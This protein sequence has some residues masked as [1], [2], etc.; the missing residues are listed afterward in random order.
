MDPRLNVSVVTPQGV[1]FEGPAQHV[2][3]P[4]ER[5]IFEVLINHKPLLSRLLPGDIFID[6]QIFPINRGVIKIAMNQVLAI[7]ETK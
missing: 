4:G 5:G 2:I 3:L 1:L 6:G 7:V